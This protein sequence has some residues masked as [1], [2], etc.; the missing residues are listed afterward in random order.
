MTPV[1]QDHTDCTRMAQHALVLGF[2]DHVQSNPFVPAEPSQ[3]ADS[4]RPYTG[5]YQF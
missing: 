5:I 2:S 1:Q 3:S 4:A